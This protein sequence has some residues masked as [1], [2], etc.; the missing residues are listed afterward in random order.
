MG[1]PFAKT[2]NIV[3]NMLK[4]GLEL[5]KTSDGPYAHLQVAMLKNMIRRYS[6]V[7]AAMTD[8]NRKVALYEFGLAPQL[9]F[10]FDCAPLCLEMYPM[11]FTQADEKG[12]QDYID[13][14]E[15]AGIPSEV[16]STDRFVAGLALDGE[17]PVNSFF[18]TCSAPCDGTRIL[19]PLM[20]K[21]MEIPCCYIETPH[22]EDSDTA[23]WYGQQIKKQLIPFLEEHTGK[24]FDIDR[25]R[26]IVEASN[27]AY[28]LIV[29]MYDMY[30]LTPAP[31]SSQ[32]RSLPWSFFLTSAGHPELIDTLEVFHQDLTERVKTNRLQEGY[33]EKHRVMWVHVPPSF[34]PGIYQWMEQQCGATMISHSLSSTPILKPIDTTNL[35]TMLE[36]YAAQGLDMTMSI[37]RFTTPKMID[38]SL[39]AYYKYNCDCIFV[40]QHVGCNNICGVS[41]LL[42]ETLREKEIPALFI[43]MDYNDSRILS[44]EAMKQQIEEFFDTVME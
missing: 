38:F 7:A 2:M 37:M 35:D 4:P 1:Q 5:A 39:Q 27:A 8:E 18:V 33:Q 31:H 12:T 44:S 16:C 25:F 34:D 22:A 20:Q 29:D 42:R 24:K 26:E 23:K 10:A 3:D 17:M 6:D 43:D 15:E 32:L 41:G 11:F 13:S 30:A 19:Y 21:V 40:T 28:E 9:F 36:G 14:A